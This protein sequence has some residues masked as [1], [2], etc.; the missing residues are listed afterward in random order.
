MTVNIYLAPEV[1]ALLGISVG[2]AAGSVIVKSN[3]AAKTPD[4]NKFNATDYP[5]EKRIGVLVKTN[6][7]KLLDLFMGEEI[8]DERYVDI[9]KV[10]MFFFT[11]ALFAGY[12]AALLS[13]DLTVMPAELVLGENEKYDLYFPLLSDAMV[14]ILGI[15]HTGYLTIKATPRIP[16]A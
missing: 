4:P 12:C 11:L 9:G 13:C 2:S 6:D 10:Q 14:T 3:K 8:G 7:P 16:R 1:W 5:E 15:S